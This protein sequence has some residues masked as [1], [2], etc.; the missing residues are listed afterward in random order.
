MRYEAV[1]DAKCDGVSWPEACE[2][3]AKI[4]MVEPET[5]WDVYK[6]VK[7]DLKQ[8]RGGRYFTPKRRRKT[9]APGGSTKPRTTP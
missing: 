3:V 8:G 6:K 7:K 4:W 5:M 2:L 1:R 9:P